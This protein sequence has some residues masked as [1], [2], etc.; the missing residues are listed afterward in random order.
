MHRIMAF[1]VKKTR[2]FAVL[3]AAFIVVA[4]AL[5]VPLAVSVAAGAG[6]AVVVIDA[7]H[8][9]IDGGVTGSASGVKES[10]LNLA[11]ARVL[12]EYVEA[13]G[14]RAVMTRKSSAGLYRATDSNKK[15]ADMQ[16]RVEIVRE[17]APVAVVSIHMNTFS[18]P[19]RRGA[20]VF[21]DAGSEKGR[22]LAEL[23][24]DELN[25][26]FNV[27]D[28]GREFSALAAEKYL[29]QNS[30]APAVIVECGFL[31]NPADEANLLDDAYR[32]EMAHAV[33]R[34]LAVFVSGGA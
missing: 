32:A 28:T 4:G 14:M 10:E 17:A 24:Q 12:A 16:R 26:T 18:S 8:G 6:G 34:A 15:R 20:Q 7:G 29:L 13:G 25:R 1:F 22:A 21:F 5:S 27:P 31:S 3:V 30:P 19:S 2:L 33:F 9:G 11:L 23:V